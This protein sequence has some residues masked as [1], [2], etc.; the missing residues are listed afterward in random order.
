MERNQ[1]LQKTVTVHED[2]KPIVEFDL[3]EKNYRNPLKGNQADIIAYNIKVLSL[4]RD[5]I[6]LE[7]LRYRFDS[8]NNGSFEDEAWRNT[9][10]DKTD[11]FNWKFE[12]A[13]NHVGKYQF[14]LY[15]EESF[16]QNTIERYVDINGEDK[17]FALVTKKMQK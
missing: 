10:L 1:L 3:A 13:E 12:V 4:D 11:Q 2:Q 6:S 5:T 17:R 9:N 7:R 14:E 8:N 15:A 16:G